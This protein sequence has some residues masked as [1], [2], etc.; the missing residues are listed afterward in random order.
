[1][2]AFSRELFRSIYDLVYPPL[3][4]Y[5][6]QTIVGDSKLFCLECLGLLDL[7]DP[8]TRCPSC[9]SMDFCL[10]LK[11]CGPCKN[12]PHVLSGLAAAFDYAGPAACLVR[13]LK[14]ADQS[15]LAKGAGAFMAAQFTRLEWPIPD[16]IVPVPIAFTHLL[17]RGYNQS[18]LLA[19]S[20]SGILNRP[21][22]EALYRKSGDFSQ[23]GLAR[24]Q[25]LSLEGKSFIQKKTGIL[26]DKIVLLVDD[27]MTTGTTL[28]RC[29]EALQGD[30]PKSIYALTV[31]RAIK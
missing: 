13:M 22:N 31:C 8:A 5:C 30:C 19:Q 14:Y 10:D 21:V 23:A 15:Y 27:V 17:E 24:K 4:I 12:R 9:F 16:V 2:Q 29:G 6:S 3:C 25:R 7:I 20:L 26:Q 11:V 18:L 28:E 1:M